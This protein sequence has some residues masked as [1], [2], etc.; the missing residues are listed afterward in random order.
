LGRDAQKAFAKI[1]TP[2]NQWIKAAIGVKM[3]SETLVIRIILKNEGKLG[4]ESAFPRL[5]NYKNKF[6]GFAQFF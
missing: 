4:N 3:N 5:K 2:S 1:A 6:T